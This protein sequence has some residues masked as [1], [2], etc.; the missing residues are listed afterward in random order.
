MGLAL[1]QFQRYSQPVED[2]QQS[3]AL[4][5]LG[6]LH[7]GGTSSGQA[8]QQAALQHFLLTLFTQNKHNESRYSL[9]VFRFLV[10]YSFS[11]D[12]CLAKSGT[13][14][15]YVSKVVFIGRGAIFNEIK[16]AMAMNNQGYFSWVTQTYCTSTAVSLFFTCLRIEPAFCPY[17]SIKSDYI[18][19]N[20]YLTR[21]LLKKFRHEQE[22]NVNTNLVDEFRT[23][24]VGKST[25]TLSGI[26][27]MFNK[28]RGSI[29]ERRKR[30]LMGIDLATIIT[31]TCL[32]YAQYSCRDRGKMNRG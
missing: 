32:A 13:V 12:G 14:T 16:K 4:R 25:V 24:I 18:L 21:N 26:G 7:H 15:Q 5:L 2:A 28:L 19:S 22:Q 31:T 20:L 30:L 8:Q 6:A 29:R 3:A 17:L 1:G 27:A 10:L 9:T 11:R 23:I